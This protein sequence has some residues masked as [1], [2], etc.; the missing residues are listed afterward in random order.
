VPLAFERPVVPPLNLTR[1]GVQSD[2]GLRCGEVQDSAVDEWVGVE[3]A[4]FVGLED[5]RGAKRARIVTG[6]LRR[7]HEGLPAV[8]VVREEPVR[9]VGGR[10]VELR[11]GR[12]LLRVGEFGYEAD[13]EHDREERR[14]STHGGPS[15]R[16]DPVTLALWAGSIGDRG[17]APQ[18]STSRGRDA[19]LAGT[20]LLA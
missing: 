15:W 4:Q 18:A 16:F 2:R 1:G 13:E 7:F 19:R 12:A 17:Q 3:R 6:Y 5:A 9:R 8:V 10:R 14:S 20:P 11:L